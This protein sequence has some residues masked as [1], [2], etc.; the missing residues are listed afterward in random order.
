MV[1][2]VREV[3]RHT[4]HERLQEGGQFNTDL[5]HFLVLLILQMSS[6]ESAKVQ[7]HAQ[8]YCNSPAQDHGCWEGQGAGELLPLSDHNRDG[9]HLCVALLVSE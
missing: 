5:P 9:V 8:C 4:S 7:L 1:V 6:P 3:I 2:V